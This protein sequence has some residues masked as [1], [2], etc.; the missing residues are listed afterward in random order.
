[1][2]NTSC[3]ATCTVTTCSC[4]S[5]D[6]WSATTLVAIIGVPGL[7][8]GVLFENGMVFDTQKNNQNHIRA[9]HSGL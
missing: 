2:F 5:T 1:M 4:T 9:V 6:Y 8:W 3:T 7:A